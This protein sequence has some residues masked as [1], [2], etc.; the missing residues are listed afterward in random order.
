MAATAANAD[1]RAR[2]ASKRGSTENLVRKKG[3]PA[4]RR[5]RRPVAP[6]GK[7]RPD[8]EPDDVWP[9]VWLDDG[10]V[11][12]GTVTEPSEVVR[13]AASELPVTAVSVRYVCS[14]TAWL[15]P[16]SRPPIEPCG[17]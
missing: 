11:A 15:I 4:A 16:S 6:R 10:V 9:D 13:D 1:Q 3:G 7:L 12:V 17:G 14:F 5:R 8:R 2:A